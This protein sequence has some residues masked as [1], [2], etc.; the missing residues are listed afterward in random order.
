[1]DFGLVVLPLA[2]MGFIWS[3]LALKRI[4]ELE[5]RID[6]LTGDNQE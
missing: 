1:M 2:L 5:D 3:L 6:I 4:N